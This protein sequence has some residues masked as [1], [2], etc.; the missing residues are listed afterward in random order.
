MRKYILAPEGATAS[1]PIYGEIV[2]S[3]YCEAEG[4]AVRSPAPVLERQLIAAEYDPARPLL[5]YRADTL[6]LKVRTIGEAA[7]LK[8]N[9]K[10]TGFAPY[11][12]VRTASP[13]RA[14]QSAALGSRAMTGC[15]G[16]RSAHRWGGR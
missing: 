10:G 6:C 7:G 14:N 11:R 2:G 5:A 12:A 15:A 1:L 3:D 9:S 13:V 16:R 4:I 8:V